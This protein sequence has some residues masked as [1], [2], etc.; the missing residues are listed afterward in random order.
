MGCE[1]EA[2]LHLCFH[3]FFTFSSL[4]SSRQI[5]L[6][7]DRLLYI[8]TENNIN[9]R[10]FIRTINKLVYNIIRHLLLYFEKS[11]RFIRIKRSTIGLHR[12]SIIFRKESPSVK[13][14]GKTNE[15]KKQIELRDSKRRAISYVCKLRKMVCLYSCFI[16][17]TDQSDT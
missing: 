6:E 11:S 5:L 13:I 8:V 9:S 1:F 10:S 14:S 4:R 3:L 17:I 15:H 12:S 2:Q 16:R 7:Y